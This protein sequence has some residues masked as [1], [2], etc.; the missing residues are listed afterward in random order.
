MP[1]DKSENNKKIVA[2]AKKEFMEQGFENASMR[3]IAADAGITVGALYRHFE[4]KEEM[5]ASLVEPTLCELRELYD[6][7]S[8]KEYERLRTMA[9]EQAWLNAE[10]KTRWI[11]SFI[12]KHFDVFKLLI[13]RSQGTRYENFIHDMALMEEK[14]DAEY[15]DKLDEYDMSVREVSGLEFHM[16][17]TANVSAM[18]EAVKH[19]FTEEQALHYAD[20]LDEFFSAG[21]KK[22]LGI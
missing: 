14:L 9:N 16:L 19:D 6:I 1:R 2:A 11:M 15:F 20:T 21:W 5:F 18:Y 4:N 8:Q 17:V 7:A 3:K 10:N 12:Y 13:C 22:I